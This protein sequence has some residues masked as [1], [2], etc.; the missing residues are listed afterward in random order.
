MLY[1]LLPI[2]C[3]TLCP[4]H[5]KEGTNLNEEEKTYFL[6]DSD[7]SLFGLVDNNHILNENSYQHF[8]LEA[9]LYETSNCRNSKFTDLTKYLL[10]EKWCYLPERLSFSLNV[11]KHK[12]ELYS[13]ENNLS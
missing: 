1:Y 4:I 7:G 13:V 5:L 11:L 10:F 3:D 9:W 12:I 8:F 2:F 6:S